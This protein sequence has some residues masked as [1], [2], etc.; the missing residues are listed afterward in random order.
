MKPVRPCSEE[1]K[2]GRELGGDAE[3]KDEKDEEN[4]LS[5]EVATEI[6]DGKTEEEGT[7]ETLGI[8]T[9]MVQQEED[10][11]KGEEGRAAIRVTAPMRVSKEEREAHELTHTR[12]TA[13][14]ARIVF[15]DGDEIQHT[16]ERQKRRRR[17]TRR[18]R[19]REFRWTTSS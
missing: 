13:H 15:E 6:E 19:S 1:A 14:G 12:P 3:M 9:S 4:G 2:P 18:W 8:G 7:S 10:N 5:Q 17:R 16:E 11:N